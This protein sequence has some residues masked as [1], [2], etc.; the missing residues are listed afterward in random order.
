MEYKMTE[1]KKRA[2]KK[3][4]ELQTLRPQLNIQES[5]LMSNDFTNSMHN[6][7]FTSFRQRYRTGDLASESVRSPVG[8]S[9][10]P[11]VRRRKPTKEKKRKPLEK[12]DERNTDEENE[13]MKNVRQVS[14]KTPEVLSD[15]SPTRKPTPKS[16]RKRYLSEN[17]KKQRSQHSPVVEIESPIW[18]VN[19]A[20]TPLNGLNFEKGQKHLEYEIRNLADSY[21]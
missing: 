20:R 12:L 17:D 6:S 8:D 9:F 13:E 19:L 5:L 2:K 1:E 14:P 10:Q 18:R 16:Q 21:T 3:C 4:S 7:N 11:S 15:R